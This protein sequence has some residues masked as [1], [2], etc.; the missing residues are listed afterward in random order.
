MKY[1]MHL[2]F[3][4]LL[5]LTNVSSASINNYYIAPWGDNSNTG[6]SLEQSWA[7]LSWAVD[8]SGKVGNGTTIYIVNGTYYNIS[9][10]NF[11]PTND[12]NETHPVLITAYNG[13]PIFDGGDAE[14]NNEYAF[15]IGSSSY[16][17][18][19]TGYITISNLTIRNYMSA[20]EIRRVSNI[21]IQNNT[22][23]NVSV[24][25][26]YG[27]LAVKDGSRDILIDN[28]LV[29]PNHGYNSINVHGDTTSVQSPTYN[30]TIS[31]NEVYGNDKHWAIQ[32]G[33][34]V[35]NI[36]VANNYVHDN[37]YGGGIDLYKGYP[38]VWTKNFIIRD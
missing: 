15:L 32:F 36:T 34:N 24:D 13:T 30:V 19:S 8:D 31:N 18:Y 27:T 21:I 10:V 3:I 33:T 2:V 4:I 28:N 29:K 35:S 9:T 37:P 17:A 23:Y 14:I 5:V 16:P 6:L 38:G 12:G 22:M 26:T 11:N 7:D 20:I 25:R 1:K